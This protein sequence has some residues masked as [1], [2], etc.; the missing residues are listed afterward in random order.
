MVT[1]A[2][3]ARAAGV[4]RSTVSYVL[5]GRRSISAETRDRVKHSIRQLG[6][7][8]HAGA[9]ALASSKT[10]VLALVAPLRADM[11]VPIVM[12]YVASVVIAARAYDYDTLLVTMDEGPAGLDRVAGGAMADALVVMDVETDDARV[13]V[14]RKLAQPA[15]LIGVPARPYG[16]SCVDLDYPAAGYVGIQYL[17]ERGHRQVALIGQPSEVY[18]R[19]TSFAERLRDG[20]RDAVGEFGV[21]S[22]TQPCEATFQGV[23]H[24]LDLVLQELPGV[25][26]LLVHNEAVLPMLLEILRARGRRVPEDISLLA[27]C[28]RE[29][30]VGSPVPLTAIEVPA[31]QIGQIAVDMLIAQLRGNPQAQTRLL[32]PVLTERESC[33]SR[34]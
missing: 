13:P 22:T 30:A 17:A 2:D 15:V 28:P 9:R 31:T 20:V 6:Y 3:V 33:V 11:N 21:A 7:H 10:S 14:L 34:T 29:V 16:I 32:A 26:A 12:Q 4:S 27:V 19:R 5:S 1:M 23:E 25:T 8:P 18:R 24:C